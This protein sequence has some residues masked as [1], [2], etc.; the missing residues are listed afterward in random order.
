[1]YDEVNI[2]DTSFHTFEYKDETLTFQNCI[3]RMI[4]RLK[5]DLTTPDYDEKRKE[6][7]EKIDDVVL[8]FAL[9]YQALWW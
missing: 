5:L 3:D 1:M 7:Q 8:I 2:V 6:Y 4:E 9:Y